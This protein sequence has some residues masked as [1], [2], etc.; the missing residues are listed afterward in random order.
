M[1]DSALLRVRIRPASSRFVLIAAFIALVAFPSA[2]WAQR[3]AV[4]I[5]GVIRDTT[6]V[7]VPQASISLR[8]TETNVRR[9]TLTN[10][11]GEHIILDIPPGTYVL[12]ASKEGFRTIN[13]PGFTLQVNQTTIVDF[14]LQVGTA[15]QTVTVD[16]QRQALRRPR[17]SWVRW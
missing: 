6:G 16:A 9:R 2:T 4:S 10:A 17:R 7:V 14:T 3:S 5:N 12:N 11:A 1:R 15:R 13:Q 8:N